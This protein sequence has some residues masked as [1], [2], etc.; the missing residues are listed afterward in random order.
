M[1]IGFRIGGLLLRNLQPRRLRF[2][3]P[4]LLLEQK[5]PPSADPPAIAPART[6]QPEGMPGKSNSALPE[7]PHTDAYILAC[8][9][10]LRNWQPSSVL[11]ANHRGAHSQKND[12]AQVKCP[13]AKEPANLV[14]AIEEH[15]VG[16]NTSDFLVIVAYLASG[17]ALR[18]ALSPQ[19]RPASKATSWQITG[20]PGGLSRSPSSRRKPAPSPSSACLALRTNSDFRF[21]QFVFGYIVG[22]VI[23][24]YCSYPPLLSRTT[25]HRLP[26]D[27]SPLRQPPANT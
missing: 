5:K 24:A 6:A 14:F 9:H 10:T 26:T 11:T 20:S 19:A 22:R 25:D 12:V 15:R 17:H 1:C 18:T 7:M 4:P 13:L 3:S 8:I 16:L 27:R 2:C 23:V 21:L